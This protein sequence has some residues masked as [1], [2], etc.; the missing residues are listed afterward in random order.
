M[1]RLTL[2][3]AL[4]AICLVSAFAQKPQTLSD[5]LAAQVAVKLPE[6]KAVESKPLFEPFFNH[7]HTP[8]IEANLS[9]G[10]RTVRI[11]VRLDETFNNP[12][13]ARNM[14][15]PMRSFLMRSVVPPGYA[16]PNLGKEAM[17]LSRGNVV[18]VGVSKANLFLTVDLTF[19][20]VEKKRRN[21]YDQTLAPKEE[22]EIA[23]KI[24]RI[25]AT[26][27]DGE[28]LISPCSNDF[29]TISFPN[30]SQTPEEKL[31]AAVSNARF[32]TIRE[33][34]AQNPNLDYRYE[35]N[36]SFISAFGQD[37][38]N[39]LQVAIRQGCFD[40]VKAIVGAGA[41]VNA[42]NNKGETPLMLAAASRH[43]EM[44]RF[45]ISSGADAKVRDKAERNAA[46]Y[47]Y[48]YHY[49]PNYLRSLYKEKPDEV[50]NAR[51]A[52]LSQLTKAGINLL[53]VTPKHKD[54]LLLELL[55]NYAANKDYVK[56]L[57]DFGID[58]N[59]EDY[60]GSTALIVAVGN[61][62]RSERNEM[63]RLLLSHGANPNQRNKR[64]FTALSLAQRDYNLY[65]NDAFTLKPIS[66]LINILKEAGAI[67]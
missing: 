12:D 59:A 41:D 45:L 27:I 35:T 66:E 7:G 11:S 10:N 34:L 49:M 56:E 47:A 25:I 50:G 40:F 64:N 62:A 23:L 14:M 20:E 58:V 3:L 29:Y 37:Q 43:L 55:K 24:A 22:Q 63:V 31:F 4:S 52:V 57:L 6:W 30:A 60:E 15:S 54:T 44:V 61:G 13:A 5:K 42:A 53:E 9:S 38:N 67:E 36:N 1:R 26:A 18:E 28:R 19:P 48:T 39:I 65:K 32:E 21:V 8:P 16:V 2:L 46:Y 17:L 51:R 33:V